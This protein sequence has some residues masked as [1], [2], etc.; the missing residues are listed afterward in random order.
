MLLKTAETHAAVYGGGGIAE[1][2]NDAS[3]LGGIAT[4]TSIS[5]L[6]IKVITFILDIVLLLAVAAIILAGIY[7][8][9]SN[10]EEGEKDKAKRVI[11]YAIIGIVVVLMSRVIVIAVNTLLS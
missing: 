3:G 11:Y 4:T 2:I 6:I 5:Q 10:G 8:I 9:I 1:G 7:L